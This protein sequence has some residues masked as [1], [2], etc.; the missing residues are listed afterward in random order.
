MGGKIYDPN[1]L[2]N[3]KAS[4]DAV[5]W[6]EVSLEN[7]DI[8]G[9]LP[10]K[11]GILTRRMPVETAKKVSVGV[12]GQSG[13]GAGG[14]ILFST[15]SPFVA[16][17]V[18]YGDGSVPTVC[19][20][21]FSYGF[22]LYRFDKTQKDVFVGAFRPV[23]GFDYLTAEFKVDTKNNRE[24]TYYTL[25]TPHF[26]EVKK[27][28]IGL[29]KGS[30][31]AR[32][33][34]YRNTKPVV[35]Y[36]SSITHGGAA[37]RPGNTYENFISQKYNLHYV[38]LGFA[39]NAKGE[40]AMAEY[41][42]DLDM[43]V[44]VCDYDHNAPNVKHLSDTHYSFYETIRKKYPEIPYIMI[45]RPDFFK[46]PTANDKRRAVIIESYKRALAAGDQN[47]YFID[48]ES[49]FEGDFYESCTSDGCHPNDLGFYRMADK[50]GAV[51]A[52]V[53]GIE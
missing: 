52:A 12:L 43:C 16:L 40:P 4:E 15:N 34:K 7:F 35:F 22:D 30:E 31:L 11:D 24:K 13:Y 25:N 47:V 9:L 3:D 44:F 17:K 51:I 39:G 8:Y 26:S 46:N 23:S 27:L 5:D 48:G 45:S 41:I 37:G 6:Y 2:K 28:Y 38:N 14:R 49:L 42:S 1:L 50:I 33:K 21:C 10:E 18:E 53:L 19:N 36:G 20:H 32:G 29:E